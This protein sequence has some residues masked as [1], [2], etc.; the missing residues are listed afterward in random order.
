[1]LQIVNKNDVKGI[2]MKKLLIAVLCSISML[3]GASDWGGKFAKVEKMYIYSTYVIVVQGDVYQGQAGCAN[4]NQW[5]FYW[6]QLDE[7]IANRVYSMLLAAKASNTP[8]QPLFD[9]TQC[10][11]EGT[12]L[13]TGSFVI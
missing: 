4:N 10:G 8:I 11:P 13:F 7:V 3:A 9:K 6:N 2:I 1:L 5:G 12:K